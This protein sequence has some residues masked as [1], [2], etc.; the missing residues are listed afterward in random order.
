MKKKADD[1]LFALGLSV[2]LLI[3]SPGHANT[4]SVSVETTSS[5]E[6]G[7]IVVTARK[8]EERL[9][10]VPLSVT[11]V[12][13]E[14]LDKQHVTSPADLE[15][16]VPGFTYQESTFGVP[17]FSIRGV[18]FYDNSLAVAPAV[19]VYLDQVPL[20]FLA[21]TPGISFDL[22]RVEALKGPQGTLFGQNSTGGAIN[23]IAAKPTKEFKS[24]VD[25]TYGR[26]N[27]IDAGGF[28][29]GPLAET[30][31][32]RVA[33]R[34]EHRG[35]WQESYTRSDSLGHRNFTTARALLDWTPS[36]T[37]KWELNINSWLDNSDTQANQYVQFSPANPVGRAEPLTVLPAY[38]LAPLNIRSA[39]WDPGQSYEKDNR[40]YQMSLRGDWDFTPTFALTSIT[41]YSDLT[42]NSLTDADGTSFNDEQVTARGK[43][44][45][46]SQEL[47]VAGTSGPFKEVLGA[48]AQFDR[49]DDNQFI[50]SAGSNQQLA[51][52]FG[53]ILFT[54]FENA[55]HQSVKT[56]AGFGSLE[57]SATD[58]L[59]LQ[60]SARYTKQD[61]DFA[62]CL[63][64]QGGGLAEGF[65]LLSTLLSGTPTTIAPGACV[66]LGPD[67]KPVPIF[68]DSLNQNNVSWRTGID[69]K[70]IVDMLVY[71]TVAKGYKAGSFS[72]LPALST[73][74]LTPVTQ[75]SVLAYEL[76][77]KESFFDRR[78]QLTSA[79]FYYNYDNKQIEGYINTG[80]P[81]GN[82]PG[83]ISVPKSSVRGAEIELHARPLTAWT[84]TL[85]AT[86]VD[87]HVDRS[88]LTPDP[89][90]T[91]IDIK[92]EQFP[93]TPRW[94]VVGD[95]EYEIPV[96]GAMNAFIG[97]GIK[98]R[99][100][101]FAAF[102]E[103]A[104]FAIHSYAL[105]D[106]RAGLQSND[107]HWRGQL[108]GRNVTDK[109]YLIQ[110][111]HSV[112][113]VTQLTGMPATFGI[114]VN[115]RY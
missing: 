12:S 105:L 77:V 19:T 5:T 111:A 49:S 13:G 86:Y 107:G 15:R 30:L 100:S 21:M 14:Q 40:F 43:I 90:G 82:L 61:R 35:D 87:S 57:F 8:R 39:D 20:P 46:L 45:S 104:L 28:V 59:T 26:F 38:P 32:A 115:Y 73:S 109:R 69:W 9:S 103:N 34:T 74:Q 65:G 101:S 92:G 17:V 41:S 36:D 42:T 84:L 95:T 110:A 54:G 70:P 98:Y 78:V 27:E 81:F 2:F 79:V 89:Y 31:S 83:L 48:N 3:D 37:L 60:G 113:T 52:P 85:G 29:S 25:L 71:G 51:T 72:T 67:H 63:R 47:R 16:V 76:G 4:N 33:V 108:W 7:E 24:G 93:N 99:T 55:D 91:I 18:G 6:I 102:G 10:D 68:Q 44:D 56:Y 114:D 112:D 58:T 80:F 50:D 53:P 64:D 62:G 23:Y 22:E 88:L 97:A 11:A 75:E 106:L 94:Q 1:A 66:S 96:S